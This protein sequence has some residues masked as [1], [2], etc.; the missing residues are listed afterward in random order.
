MWG[1]EQVDIALYRYRK[2]GIGH[3]QR[4]MNV[5]L[6]VVFGKQGTW[7][8][9]RPSW[10]MGLELDRYYKNLNLAFEFQG[11][12][13]YTDPDQQRRDRE[14]VDLC[15][16]NNVLLLQLKASDLDPS[17]FIA[18]LGGLLRNS[19]AGRYVD[20]KKSM[21][22]FTT[23]EAYEFLKQLVKDYRIVL[24]RSYGSRSA[25]VGNDHMLK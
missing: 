21:R 4:L 18:K 1:I 23:P 16:P 6:D 7:D 19:K 10:L 15:V 13:H 14:K 11:D 22:S 20:G 12:Q 8:N 24:Q 2:P 3:G 17:Q 9:Y 5:L 25:R